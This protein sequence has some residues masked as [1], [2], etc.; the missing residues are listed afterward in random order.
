MPVILDVINITTK[1]PSLRSCWC[2]CASP[3]LRGWTCYSSTKGS[4]YPIHIPFLVCASQSIVPRRKL[5]TLIVTLQLLV[6]LYTAIFA[7]LGMLSFHERLLCARFLVVLTRSIDSLPKGFNEHRIPSL[8]S[9][10]CFCTSPSSRGWACCSSTRARRAASGS[11]PTNAPCSTC[12]ISSRCPTTPTYRSPPT[13]ES[14]WHLVDPR[15]VLEEG[16]GGERFEEIRI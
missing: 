2:F 4:L 5:R 16:L 7:W 13:S 1:H 15:D 9:C 12:S 6:V 8:C 3:S 10:W 14:L 11:P